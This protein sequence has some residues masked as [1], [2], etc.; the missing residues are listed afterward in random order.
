MV[1]QSELPSRAFG[2]GLLVLALA[3]VLIAAFGARSVYAQSAPTPVA[4][5]FPGK[6]W[7]LVSPESEGYSSKK[8]EALRAWLAAGPTTSMMI[9]V[10]GHLIF[11][12]G[13]TAK[14]SKI[15]AKAIAPFPAGP[16]ACAVA[17][18]A[19]IEAPCPKSSVANVWN[20][21]PARPHC[22]TPRRE[23]ETRLRSCR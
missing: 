17:M 18:P 8:L 10:H 4:P 21:L 22:F 6:D 14:V 11:R 19:A 15:A 20:V 1:V 23:R 16:N 9:V 12:Y 7:Q 2:R 5:D 13:D 3:A